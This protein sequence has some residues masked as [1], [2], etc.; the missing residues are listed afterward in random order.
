MR[1]SQL[2]LLMTALVLAAG[3]AAAQTP[4]DTGPAIPMASAQDK[5]I[6]L[7]MR[8]GSSTLIDLRNLPRTPP[9]K[10]DWPERH[11]PPVDRTEL[12]GGRPPEA[13]LGPVITAP[14]PSPIANFI[15]LDFNNWGAGR[16]PDTVGDVGPDHFIQAV[17]TSIGIYRK[18]DG[19]LLAAFTFDTFMSQGNFG[20]LCD[21][22][23]FGDPVILYDT[24]EDRWVITD[25]AF[26][27]DGANNV[28]N[29]PGAFECFAVSKTG[30]PVAGGWNFYSIQVTDGLNDYPKLG[31]WPDGIYMSANL[32]GFPAGG[33]FLGTRVWALNKAQMYANA[34]TVQVIQFNP[35]SNEFTLLPA[36]AR[37]QTGTP[38]IGAP[39]YFGVVWNFTNAA[40]VYKFKVDWDRTSLSSFTGPFTSI[41]PASWTNAPATVPALG[42][43][44]NDTLAPRLMMQNQYTNIGGVESI[45]LTHTVLGG[46][47]STAAPR[48]YQVGVTGGSISANTTQAATH[49]PDTS[50]NRYIPS[51]AVDRGGNM[52]MGY[53]A[54]SSTLRPAIRWAGRLSSDPVNTLPQ[55]ET[56]LI[57]GTGSQNTSNRWGDY[58]AMNLA[59]DGCTF[60]FTTEYYITTGGNWQTRIGSTAF[61]SCTPVTSGTVQGTVTAAS[62]GAPISGAT[63]T[64]GSRKAS[65]N[66]SGVYTFTAIPSGNYPS[67]SASSAG[68][69]SGSS[70]NVVVTDGATTTRDFALATAPVAACLTDT[71]QADFQTGTGSNIDLTTSPGDVT[72]LNTAVLDQQNTSVTTSGFGFTSTAWFGQTFTA[73]ASGQLTQVDVNLF[74]SG[75]T[76]TTPNITVSIRAASGDL[77]TGADLATATIPGFSS[78]AGGYFTATFASPPTLVSGTAYAIVVR[79]VSN[80]S[81][82][83]Y[84]YVVSTGSPYA[85]GRRVTS[86]NSGSTWSGQTTD[87]GFRTYV[88]SGF[89][90]A[91]TLISGLKDTNPATGNPSNWASLTWNAAT[92]ANTTLRYQAAASNSI[93]GPFNFVGPDSTAGTFF[94]TSGASLAQ[95]NGNRYLKYKVY[96][97]TTNT[98]ATPTVNDVTVCYGPVSADVS[99][100]KTDGVSSL[101]AGANTTYTI[102]ASNPTVNVLSNVGVTDS[103]PASLSACTWTCAAS[104][105]GSCQSASGSNNIATTTNS[106]G[107]SGTLTFSATCTLGAAATGTVANTA[108]VSYAN[109]PTAGNNSATDTNSIVP[110]ADLSITKT[111]GSATATAGSNVSYTIVASNP[112]AVAVSNVGV[113]DTFAGTLSACTWSCTASSGGSCQAASG[114][115]NI[116]TTTN[117]IGAGGTL[118]LSATCTLSAAATGT[119][120]NTATVSY[121]NDPTAGNNSAT[122]TDTIL[123]PLADLSITKTDGVSSLNA[124]ANTTYTIVASNPTANVL[125]DVGV[126]D[127]F[128]ASLSACTWTCAASAGGS[129]Q[130]ASGGGNIATTTN[131]LGASGTLTFSATCTLGAAATGTVANTATVSYANDPTA[132]NNSATDTDTIVPQSDLS[133]TKTDGSATATAGSNVTYTIVASNP[134]AVA[135]SNVGVADTFAG[136]LSACT[137]SCTASSGGSCQAASGSGNIATTTNSIGAGGT[138]SFSATCTL[139]AAATGTLVNTATVSYA[140]DPTAGN[141]SAADTD[142]ILPPLADLSIT[143]TDGV[144][145]L[146]A[147]ANTTYTIV[148]SNPT[149]NVLSDVGVTDT[150]PASLSACTWTCAASA[151]GS[152]QSASGGGNIATTTNSLGA[153]GTLTF[154]A[155]CTL[156][157]AATG[158]V[159]NSATVSYANDPTAGNNSATDTN[160][161]VP[162]AD[163]S[164]TKTDGSATATAGSNV[165]YTIVAS[166][167]AAVA[168]SNVG[169][170]DTFAG[171]LST[172]TWSCTA[173]SGGSCQAASGSGNI[174][175]TTNSIAA[176]G[177]LSF[178]ATC[179]L[180]AAA[181]GTLVNTATVSYANDPTAGNNSATDTD[182]ILP[183]LA[184][185]SITKTDGVSSLNAGANTTY[186]IVASNPTANVLSNVGVTDTFP[187]SLSSCTWTCAASS[188]GGCQNASGSGN[189]A[190]TTNSLGAS[191]TLTFSATCTLG[192]AAT[193]TVAN[194][195]TVSYANDPT[196]GNNSATDTNS[197]V[198]Q[199]DLSITK[200]DGVSAAAPGQNLNY[201]IVASN[202]AGVAISDVSITDTFPSELGSCTWTCSAPS[203][204][205]CQSPSGSGNI[206]TTSNSIG[207]GGSL[208]F[209]ASCTL[210]P[211]ASGSVSNTASVGYVNDPNGANNSATD[212]NTILA[213]P[214][215]SN[216]FE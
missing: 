9:L 147:G 102:V 174:A 111:D 122:D 121:T 162:Q 49:T 177:T 17:N 199:A 186:T 41:A 211:A 80:P 107:A 30:D 143:K 216:G 13:P 50:V 139:S 110:Q 141:N 125:S 59:P 96:L 157:A 25:F 106:I 117:S 88:K 44:A 201:T 169:I 93:N 79:A 173:S 195:A 132:G 215:F 86:S 131:S 87:V 47:A 108:T 184:D 55:T 197:I 19:V 66:G 83:T 70:S 130:N 185:L 37:L 214:L 150:F 33:S 203:G 90:T 46:A 73:G 100:T 191:G 62:G 190:T 36:N 179:T 205:S 194:T 196:P 85:N 188:G 116:A 4:V 204:G 101:N 91:G 115:G 42:G 208:S 113:A 149:A 63:V 23:N 77:P 58:A 89:A 12:P 213:D 109:D 198:P 72:L 27:L 15:G 126:T 165:T 60:W 94:T 114:S 129:C 99:I 97:S 48:W 98:A 74:C 158:T 68:F 78:G 200:S 38:P 163:L 144:S 2:K 155:T 161:I 168:V 51:L 128:P 54:S 138:L 212:V 135:V 29:P 210:S 16:P 31:I 21:T 39:N 193:G 75:C 112:T 206:A 103:F 154:S 140:N 53:S 142:T 10:R 151:G 1:G 124:G 52:L 64:M 134:A 137:W 65:T 166:N 95:F 76:G 71:T 160:S 18:T 92:P 146:N 57:E 207:A 82:G 61:P 127:T 69:V 164:I 24:F 189:I 180:S 176:S 81:A 56:S 32:F 152:C 167:P 6:V 145:S 105:G 136:T 104:S 45:W 133:I 192:A 209:V 34:P 14:A 156:G 120:V 7:E 153:S 84:A 170:A 40:S 35:P 8:R 159:A 11:D 183:P 20:N 119:L 67:I 202:P 43:N 123:P 182:T 118:S 26:Q 148:A 172:C 187:A 22:D 181:T 175:T 5:P 171:T 3:G 178:S 28:V